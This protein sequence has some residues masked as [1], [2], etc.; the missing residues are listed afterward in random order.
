MQSLLRAAALLRNANSLD[1]LVSLLRFVGFGG[2]ALRLD[3][4]TISA[5]GIPPI[6][7]SARIAQGTGSL[8]ALIVM[9]DDNSDLREAVSELTSGL[10][11]RAPQ[12]LWLVAAL[13]SRSRE[14]AIVTWSA[15]ASRP[16]ILSLL[17]NTER[18]VESDAETLCALAAA[19]GESDLLTHARWVDV[20]GREVITQKFFRSLQAVVDELADSLPRSTS[21]E[22][23]RELAL[24]YV[25]RLIFLSFLETKGW[26]SGDFGFLSNGF[27]RCIDSGG[28][29]QKRILEP[30]FFGTLN[31]RVSS[32][33][34]LAQ[35]FGRVP[36][37]NGGLFSR[38]HFEKS[39][40]ACT[41]TDEAFGNAYSLLF[42]R[43]RFSAHEETAEWSDASIDPEILGKAFEALMASGDRKGTGAFY[44]PHSLVT[45]V[46]DSALCAAALTSESDDLT[47]LAAAVRA[48]KVDAE[49]LSSI[50]VLDPACGSGAFLV[51]VLEQLAALRAAAGEAGSRGEIRRRVLVGSIFGVDLNS[52][53]VWLCQLRLWLSIV[54]ETVDVDPMKVIPLPNLDRHVRCGDSL[55]GG[56]LTG[57][58]YLIGR[59]QLARLRERYARATGPR[60]RTIARAMDGAERRLTL[61]ALNRQHSDLCRARR[62]LLLALRTRDLFGER[63]RPDHETNAEL[64]GLR[65]R[66]RDVKRQADSVRAGGA[67]PFS[68]AA[69]F[70]DAAASGGFDL[71]IGNPP[72]VRLHRI[73]QSSRDRLRMEFAVYRNASWQTGARAAGAGRGFAAQV[74]MSALFIERGYG[75]LKPGGVLGFLVPAKLWRSLAGGG[76]R[77]LLTERT[78]LLRIDDMSESRSGFDAA[79]YPSVLVCRAR[80]S[81]KGQNALSNFIDLSVSKGCQCVRWRCNS[82][83][84]PL[85]DSIGSPWLLLPP[86]PRAAFD[87]VR[88]AGS[89]LAESQF[90]RPQLGVKT[91]LNEAF[92][93]RLEGVDGDEATVTS[94]PRT[95]TIERRMLR[96]LLRGETLSQWRTTTS[97][98]C[99]VWPYGPDGTAL[100]QLPPLT[101]RWLLPYYRDLT[102]RTDLRGGEQWWTVFRTESVRSDSPRVV[103]ADFGLNPR[104]AVIERGEPM[105]PL[106]T[107][108]VSRCRTLEDAHALSALLNSPLT[109]AWLNVIAEPARGGYRRYLGWTVALLPI[110]A[111]WEIARRVMA[112]QSER[113]TAGDLPSRSELLQATLSAYDLPLSDIEALLLWT[114]RSD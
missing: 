31:T 24:L 20:L 86:G 83:S 26:L 103:W 25:S 7:Q 21:R 18:V 85:D 97:N 87:R 114:S 32:R 104:A 112:P 98:E 75:L 4:A 35:A 54:V 34:P 8:R 40:R 15:G 22:K 23:R 107:C 77:T 88:S 102:R 66:I 110:P 9:I 78:H 82:R 101:R 93:V 42:S 68:F 39:S 28:R 27:A 41:M 95:G 33:A 96:P 106:N 13:R 62:E 45:E 37:L 90:G 51:Q 48:G 29:Y 50:R 73:P 14:L 57:E 67:L 92:L 100:R 64:L 99:V 74:D 60:K 72:W 58:K 43:Y 44:T 109:S 108:Y 56:G 3:V 55:T 12:M 11:H 105:V 52:M 16:R 36:F 17:C 5:L 61:D 76:V 71:V 38:S 89:P 80:D 84:V 59:V 30:L 10:A 113:A 49:Y 91:G 2:D 79:V 53:A 47:D 6:V 1:G 69:H 19:T 70:P 63:H 81:Q 46:T 94:G 111:N 65:S